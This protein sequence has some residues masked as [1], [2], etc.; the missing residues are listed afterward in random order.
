VGMSTC[1]SMVMMKTRKTELYQLQCMCMT[2]ILLLGLVMFLVSLIRLDVMC[3]LLKTVVL[4]QEKEVEI[5]LAVYT[6]VQQTLAFLLEKEQLILSAT[7]NQ[8]PRML[9]LLLVKEYMTLL[10]ACILVQQTL[11]LPLE[12]E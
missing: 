11:A 7:H 3:V 9:A 10:V 6:L 12:R 4:S 8:A 2:P 5:L 1:M